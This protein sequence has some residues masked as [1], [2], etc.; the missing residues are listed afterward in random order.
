MRLLLD[1]QALLWSVN[2]SARLG[3]AARDLIADPGN[4]V[5]VSVASLWEIAI[6]VQTGK[7]KADVRELSDAIHRNDVALLGISIAHL[8]ALTSLPRHHKDP[9]DHLL[10]AQAIA[11]NATLMSE[12]RWM[13]S[14]PVPVV[15]CSA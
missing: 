7:L 3:P 1:T 2:D 6:K 5:M 9:F 15:S 12:D 13:P 11:E 4:E 14:Y 8:T 10:I